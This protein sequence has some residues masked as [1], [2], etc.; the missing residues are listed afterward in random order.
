MRRGL[1][2]PLLTL[3]LLAGPVLCRAQPTL[4]LLCVG[5]SH[6]E[7]FTLDLEFADR[8]AGEFA[9]EFVARSG[10]AFG[11]TRL[12]L[13]TNRE[14]T[15]GR[16]LAELALTCAVSGP[17][18][19]VVLFFSGH[20]AYTDKLGFYLLARDTHT[21]EAART[22]L[23]WSDVRSSLWSLNAARV[24]LFIDACEAGGAVPTEPLCK[25]VPTVT[26]ASSSASQS[27]NEEEPL[28]HGVFTAAL[29]AALRGGADAD[30]DGQI[31]LG[32]LGSWLPPAVSRL[33]KGRQTPKPPDFGSV[34][35]AT[36][37]AAAG[38]PGY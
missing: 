13:L 35:P 34:D 2:L 37:L 31:S 28:G 12:A 36:T 14:A 8:D 25:R 4:H 20:G 7:D 30:L 23:L 11:Q 38:S 10:G 6:H 29:L 22:A 24:L 33:S 3:L 18:D 27:S 21:P 5:I 9:R 15:R 1:A 17:S 26:F 19:T 16:I 32:E